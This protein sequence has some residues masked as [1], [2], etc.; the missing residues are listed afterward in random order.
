LDLVKVGL[1]VEGAIRVEGVIGV[2]GFGVI[3]VVL[4]T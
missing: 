2:V 1:V 3:G 4:V